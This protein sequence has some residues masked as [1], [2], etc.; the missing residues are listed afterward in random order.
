MAVAA[1]AAAT[2]AT[3]MLVVVVVYKPHQLT[4]VPDIILFDIYSNRN[5]NASRHVKK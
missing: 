2:V 5:A 1:A 3:H 4:I